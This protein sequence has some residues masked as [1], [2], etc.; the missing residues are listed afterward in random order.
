MSAASTHHHCSILHTHTQHSRT[1]NEYWILETRIFTALACTLIPSF[2]T[3]YKNFYVL[4][5]VICHFSNIGI[6][7][8]AR[9]VWLVRAHATQTNHF[10]IFIRQFFLWSKKKLPQFVLETQ[11]KVSKCICTKP[12]HRAR[13]YTLSCATHT[14]ERSC[15][16][17]KRGIVN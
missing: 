1:E 4:Y 6:L 16:S 15:C 11:F 14:A 13:S 7:R 9:S 5:F 10:F 12:K 17:S 2:I 8:A 3:L